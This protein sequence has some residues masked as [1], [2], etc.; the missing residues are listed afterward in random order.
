MQFFC[1]GDLG[2][3]AQE[4]SLEHSFLCAEGALVTWQFTGN[5]DGNN[6]SEHVFDSQCGSSLEVDVVLLGQHCFLRF[7][8]RINRLLRAKRDL[9]CEKPRGHDP[10]KGHACAGVYSH[11]GCVWKVMWQ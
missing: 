10:S 6:N 1:S 3:Q 7:S 4:D 8:N 5:A 2:H 11:S 9:F